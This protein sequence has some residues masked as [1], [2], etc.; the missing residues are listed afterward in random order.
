MSV[1]TRSENGSSPSVASRARFEVR[2]AGPDDVYI[3]GEELLALQCANGINKTFVSD[4]EK[5]QSSSEYVLC[6]ATVHE[7]S[8]EENYVENLRSK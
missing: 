5:C 7:I 6:V 2:V 3:F 4:C 1:L 8:G